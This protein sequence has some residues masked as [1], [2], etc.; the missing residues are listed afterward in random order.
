MASTHIDYDSVAE[1]YDLYVTGEY[2]VSFFIE[3]F[4]DDGRLVSKQ[5][6]PMKFE[7]IERHRFEAMARDAGFEVLDVYG[8]YDRSEF[9]PDAS[10]VMIWVL[11]KPA[12]GT[13][14]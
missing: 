9:D 14:E 8:N 11:Q 7:F 5:L 2:D 12:A 4:A 3:R 13:A 10:P 1:I 6:L